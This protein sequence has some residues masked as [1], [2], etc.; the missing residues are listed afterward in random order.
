MNRSTVP[1]IAD[2]CD[3]HKRTAGRV[4]AQLVRDGVI[5]AALTFHEGRGV[6]TVF[7]DRAE[8]EATRKAWADEMKARLRR[9]A[10]ER[11]ARYREKPENVEKRVKAAEARAAKEAV[12]KRKQDAKARAKLEKDAKRKAELDNRAAERLRARVAKPTTA[13]VKVSTGRGPAHLPGEPDLS[14]AKII[15]APTPPGRFEHR[16]RVV[17]GFAAMRLG[18]YE[19]PANSCAAKRAA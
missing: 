2:A 7:H 11:Q 12:D 13:T 15:V 10:R 18:C 8:A 6:Y 19:S 14:R 1:E 16:G 5:Y 17:D 3:V 4:V 9:R